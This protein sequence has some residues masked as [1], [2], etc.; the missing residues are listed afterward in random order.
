MGF[1]SVNARMSLSLLQEEVVRNWD[2]WLEGPCGNGSMPY[3]GGCKCRLV[4][5]TI[6]NFS[7]L[8]LFGTCPWIEVI[9]APFLRWRAFRIKEEWGGL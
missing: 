5:P 4:H 1:Y 2:K 8:D 3:F 9:A 6:I 7:L